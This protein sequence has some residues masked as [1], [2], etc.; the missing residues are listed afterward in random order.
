MSRRGRSVGRLQC[1]D[2]IH[3]P[4]IA[5]ASPLPTL[6]PASDFIHAISAGRIVIGRRFGESAEAGRNGAALG[7]IVAKS[8]ACS[9]TLHVAH[10]FLHHLL[11]VTRLRFLLSPPPPIR[12]LPQTGRSLHTHALRQV[13]ACSGA[14]SVRLCAAQPLSVLG[15]GALSLYANANDRCTNARGCAN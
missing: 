10:V 2:I 1:I 6:L 9:V 14:L 15:Y 12:A 8:H 7:E 11:V 3:G 4:P 13:C 5:S